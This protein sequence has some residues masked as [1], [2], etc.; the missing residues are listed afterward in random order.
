M[1]AL[2]FSITGH[3]TT[4]ALEDQITVNAKWYATVFLPEVVAQI[5]KSIQNHRII[6]YLYN[7]SSTNNFTNYQ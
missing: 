7:A 4:V 1:V 2:I 3:V 6:L 5:Q